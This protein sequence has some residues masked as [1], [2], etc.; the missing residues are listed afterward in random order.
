MEEGDNI[1]FTPGDHLEVIKKLIEY[2]ADYAPNDHILLISVRKHLIWMAAGFN[3]VSS[4]RDVIFKTPDLTETIKISEDFF[5]S[6][7]DQKKRLQDHDSFMTSGH[8]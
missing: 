1:F 8:G 2:S 6:L 5:H 7:N 3:N 4:F